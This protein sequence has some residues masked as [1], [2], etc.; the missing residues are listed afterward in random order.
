MRKVM[1]SVM[2]GLLCGLVLAPVADRSAV[3]A[4]GADESAFVQM[5]N[6][7]R[8]SAGL[9]AL[10]VDAELTSLARGWAQHQ[11]DAGQISHANPISAGVT[12]PWQKLGENVGT[13]PSVAP[14]MDAFMASAGHRA[15]VLDPEFT[16]VGVGVVWN[17][18]ALYTTHR[19]MA[20][21]APPPPP[22]TAPP[23]TEA[24]PP[25]PPTAPPTTEAPPPPPPPP[26][27]PP[28]TEAPPP[29]TST[30]TTTTLVS[31]PPPAPTERVVATLAALRSAV[32]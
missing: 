32:L 8:T 21:P 28:T 3:S 11:A 30:T 2:L 1:V 13:G 31:T 10:I 19:F 20:L 17:G 6:Q 5:I 9:P 18:P 4:S 25:P 15:N 7:A 22:P 12:S 16:H 23:T 14:V 29:T 26:T 24:P 27:A